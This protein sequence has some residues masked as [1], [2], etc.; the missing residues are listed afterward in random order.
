MPGFCLTTWHYFL[1]LLASTF[2]ITKQRT[3]QS[4]RSNMSTPKPTNPR[5]MGRT[6]EERKATPASAGKS[7]FL[8][9][10][11]D[12]Y[13]HFGKLHNAVRDMEAISNL[14]LRD[15]D[16]HEDNCRWLR[17]EEATRKGILRSLRDLD[18]WV[19]KDDKLIIY[20]SG[21]GYRDKNNLGFW[22]S[23]KAEKDAEEDFV[24]NLELKHIVAHLKARHVLLISD[25]CFSGTLFIQG[26][27]RADFAADRLESIPSRWALCSGRYNQLVADG[28]KGGHSPF[29]ESILT[30]LQRNPKDTLRIDS[31]AERVLEFTA[32]K[33]DQDQLSQGNPLQGVGHQGGQYVFRRRLNEA[34]IWAES[35]KPT[36]SP[37]PTSNKPIPANPIPASIAD[38]MVHIPGGTFTMGCQSFFLFKICR[39]NEKPAHRVTVSSFYLSKYL[40]TQAQWRAVMGS[41]PSS[42]KGCD[43]CPVDNI[44]WNDT[45]VFLQ[46]LNAQTGQNYR[47]P[48]EAEWEFA[49]RGGN[50][51]KGYDYSG[52]NTLSKVAWYTKPDSTK[53]S[54][55]VGGKEPNELGLYD[56]SGNV[57]EWCNDKYGAYSNQPQVDP[58]GAIEGSDRVYRGVEWSIQQWYCRVAYR[59]HLYQASD[60]WCIGFRLAL[61]PSSKK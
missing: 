59:A 9:I 41:D 10:G 37:P 58:I 22:V 1:T 44:R 30:E 39:D 6:A 36:T 50:N 12:K 47:L 4:Q 56:M 45:Q 26:A 43:Q 13:E 21:H 55:P 8:G 2:F 5:G 20:Y 40:V 7:C 48:T 51:S 11:I 24:S 27:S 14:L 28:P 15:Y 49:A 3:H 29:A 18:N 42:N 35:E 53:R 34:Q 57:G 46:K 52:S 23:V 16:L 60:G 33:Y 61:S 19:G 25:A 31:L 54:H 38:N 32:G 17:N